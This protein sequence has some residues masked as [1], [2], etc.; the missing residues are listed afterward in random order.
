MRKR[1]IP[2]LNLKEPPEPPTPRKE[3]RI[4][5]SDPLP[6]ESARRSLTEP[7]K[8]LTG[9]YPPMK[10]LDLQGM[11]ANWNAKPPF[12][13]QF[14][15]SMVPRDSRQREPGHGSA[16]VT[17]HEPFGKI[18]RGVRIHLPWNAIRWTCTMRTLPEGRELLREWG[19]LDLERP[20][21]PF[22]RE[23]GN[24]KRPYQM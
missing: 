17:S 16:R 19:Q 4:R 23:L 20:G 21:S 8:V 9:L 22:L 13:P 24:T 1:Q 5:D 10:L 2:H 18:E 3:S 11:H 12:L 14:R 6:G 15:L 7:S